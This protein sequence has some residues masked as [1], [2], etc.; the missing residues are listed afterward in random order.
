VPDLEEP[1]QKPCQARGGEHDGERDLP[2]VSAQ[3][4]HLCSQLVGQ[5]IQI[6]FGGE[7][8]NYDAA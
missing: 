7:F 1:L 5:V 2:H 3:L 4:A 8:G 6:L